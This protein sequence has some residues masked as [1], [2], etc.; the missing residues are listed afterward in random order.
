MENTK[1]NEHLDIVYDDENMVISVKIGDIKV[2]SILKNYFK[3]TFER[4]KAYI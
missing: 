1:I 3:V 4:M 2:Y